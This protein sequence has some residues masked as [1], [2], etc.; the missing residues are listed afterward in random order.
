MLEVSLPAL[1]AS[2]LYWIDIIIEIV[3]L[4]VGLVFKNTNKIGFSALL[5][6]DLTPFAFDDLVETWKTKLK[7]DLSIGASIEAQRHD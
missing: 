3:I 4:L 6:R 7:Q 2:F 1:S 5:A